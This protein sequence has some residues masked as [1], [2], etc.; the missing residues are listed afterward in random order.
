M[1]HAARGAEEIRR[2]SRRSRAGLARAGEPG[3]WCQGRREEVSLSVCRIRLRLRA[4]RPRLLFRLC[5]YL[6]RSLLRWSLDA[7]SVWLSLQTGPRLL[8]QV[9]RHGSLRQ[10]L[11]MHSLWPPLF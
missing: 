6:R 5:G 9:V 2:W 4:V 1:R 3:A 7:E 10:F 8:L 11:R